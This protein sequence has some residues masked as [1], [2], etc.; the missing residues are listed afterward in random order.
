MI[1]PSPF[2]RLLQELSKDARVDPNAAF[3]RL[4]EI[5]GKTSSETDL[6]HFSVYA[7]NL[8]VGALGRY[9][10]AEALLRRCL[11]HPSLPAASPVRRSIHRA[12]AVLLIC[13]ERK[14]D[15]EAEMRLGIIGPS[16][17]C[18]FAS[19]CAQTL[20]ARNR[21]SEALPFLKRATVL[22]SVVPPDDDVLKQTAGIAG[23]LLRIAEPQCL[24]TQQLLTTAGDAL[25]AATVRAE[26]WKNHHQALFNQGKAWL[27][28]INP[29][30]A[31]SIVQEMMALEK[32]FDAGPAQR[33]YSANLACRAQAVRGQFKV[34]ASA[35]AACQQLVAEGEATGE[36]LGPA[37]EDLERFVASLQEQKPLIPDI[38]GAVPIIAPLPS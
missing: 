20:L 28:A 8:G 1:Q 25:A 10:D 7:T 36:P 37:A 33:F 26:N 30:R 6:L 19:A 16:D 22:C 32:K 12:L 2:Q 21:P 27:L 4:D 13:A 31:L 9:D 24:L 11:E 35:M 14:R 15:A 34:A 23:N 17:E 5:Y 3:N 18:R 29:V 38:S